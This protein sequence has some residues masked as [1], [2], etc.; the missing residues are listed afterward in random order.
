MESA[1]QVQKNNHDVFEES[2]VVVK[3]VDQIPRARL[4]E[5]L[6]KFHFACIRG[7][8]SP[9]QVIQ[10]KQQLVKNFSPT[11]DRPSKGEKPEQVMSLFQKISVGS[12]VQSGGQS[13]DRPRFLRILY[14]PFW[15]EDVFG[16]HDML[17]KVCQVRNL[18]LDQAPDF[19]VQQPEA[20]LWT[21]SRIHQFPQG[22]GFFFAHRDD[23]LKMVF[24]ENKIASYYHPFLVMSRK[25]EDFEKGGGFFELNGQRIFFEEHCQLGDIAIYDGR[26]VHGVEEVDSHKPLDLSSFN[27]RMAGFVSLYRDLR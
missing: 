6:E 17:R 26:T 5:I 8:V 10:A 19:C 12:R 9:E 23:N 25:G 20:G 24:E 13:Y 27:G 21:A 15:E 7:L 2:L 1:A 3:E 4:L 11:K 16:V 18:L 14:T 22:G